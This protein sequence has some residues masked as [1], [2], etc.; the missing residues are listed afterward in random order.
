MGGWGGGAVTTL[1]TTK[2]ENHN[3]KQ[4]RES[5][6]KR[7]KSCHVR[8]VARENMKLVGNVR[9]LREERLL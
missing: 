8:S 1:L 6:A 5:S 7:G 2:D 3:L 4:K 9:E